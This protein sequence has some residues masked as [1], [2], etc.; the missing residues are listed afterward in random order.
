MKLFPQLHL[1]PDNFPE[2]QIIVQG[3]PGSAIL[4]ISPYP[5]KKQVGMKKVSIEEKKYIFDDFFKVEEAYLRFEQ[6]NGK[7]SPRIRRLNMERGNS[8]A[9]VILNK[10][11]DKLIMVSQ[12]RYPTYQNS[13]GWT[14]EIIAG[15]IDPGETPEQTLRRELDEEIGLDLE[16]FEHISVFY[17]SPGGSSEQI[18][19]YYAEVSGEK[20]KYKETGGLLSHGEDV[21]AL[22]L[23]LQAALTKVKSGE[24]VD[25]KTII[26]VFWLEN[27]RIS[28]L[29]K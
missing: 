24:I 13:D 5:Y 25:A 22:E 9:I 29:S 10:D 18:Y 26:G 17:P 1:R 7:M 19:L 20:A 3:H 15:M 21:K 16:T 27:R 14:I 28:R 4:D 12:F 8:V 23:S 11:T 6:F 2:L